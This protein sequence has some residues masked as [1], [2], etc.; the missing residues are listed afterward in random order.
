MQGLEFRFDVMLQWI[1][2]R[3]SQTLSGFSVLWQNL[4]RSMLAKQTNNM[5]I[6]W[7]VGARALSLTSQI[8][9]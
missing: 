4:V 5:G 2:V 9:S 1:W 3:F 8:S 7:C 6:K